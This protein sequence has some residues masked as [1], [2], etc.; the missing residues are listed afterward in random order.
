MAR[1]EAQDPAATIFFDRAIPDSIA[2]Y[3]RLGE[4]PE[5]VVKAAKRFHYKRI[6]FLEGLPFEY[7]GLR[8][9]D[10]TVAAVLGRYIY[11]AYVSLGYDVVRVPVLPIEERVAFILDRAVGHC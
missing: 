4:V 9:E 2:Y 7:D 10:E 8:R 6:F 1:E 5:F 3:R 11:D